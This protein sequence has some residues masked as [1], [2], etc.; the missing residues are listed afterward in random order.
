MTSKVVSRFRV[1]PPQ[2][3]LS[4]LVVTRK[5]HDGLRIVEM[6]QNHGFDLVVAENFAGAKDRMSH[7]PPAVLITDL[8]LGEFNGLHL[9]LRGK[10]ARPSMSAIVIADISDPVL[11]DEAERMGATFVVKPFS[12]SDLLAI[13]CRTICNT[14]GAGAPI[15]PPFER[16]R[17]ERRVAENPPPVDFRQGDR[18][19]GLATLLT[20]AAEVKQ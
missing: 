3:A 8:R 7:Y 14:S 11:Q 6:L 15:R 12:K 17:T 20:P 2:T 9:V 1:R 4:T 13:L 18:R 19:R 16:R 5:L 10:F